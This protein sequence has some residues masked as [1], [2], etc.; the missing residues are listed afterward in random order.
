MMRSL[1]A[2]MSGLQAHQTMVDVTSNNIANANTHGYKQSRVSFADQLSQNIFGGSRPTENLGG[3]NGVQVGLGVRVNSI[4]QIMSQGSL[5]QTGNTLDLAVSGDGFFVVSDGA[6]N[7][8]T[9]NGAFG[10]D[11]DGFITLQGSAYRVMGRM[12]SEDGTIT[13]T[14]ST[15]ALK[16]PLQMKIAAKATSSID[17]ACNLDADA[18]NSIATLGSAGT[19]GLSQVSG[20]AVDG[21]GGTH[22]LSITG[23]NATRDSLTSTQTTLTT[24]TILSSLGVSGASFTITVDGGTAQTI[25]GLSSGSSIGDLINAINTQVPGAVAQLV[26]SGSPATTSLVV[27]RKTYGDH[28]THNL[29]FADVAGGTNNIVGVLFGTNTVTSGGTNSTLS[30]LDTF[31]ATG[32]TTPS[33]TDRALTLSRN[34][35]GL[36]IGIDGLGNGGVTMTAANGLASGTASITTTDTSHSTSMVVYDSLGVGHNLNVTFS[37]SGNANEWRWAATLPS[38]SSATLAGNTGTIKF[39]LDGSLNSFNYDGGASG[40]SLQAS[41]GTEALN[42]NLNAGLI[43]SLKGITQTS[44]AFSTAAVSQNGYA[45]GKLDGISV[46][47]SGKIIGS[48]TNGLNRTLAEVDLATFSNAQGLTKTGGNLFEVSANSGDPKIGAATT[49]NSQIYSGYLELSNVDLTKEFTNLIIGQRGFSANS[50]AVQSAD[51]MLME[52]LQIKR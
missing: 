9:R 41:N 34:S 5:E 16:L 50:R 20:T 30:A 24:D 45:S 11:G 8:Y 3:I 26:T 10:M 4:D 2:A 17:F 29:E 7:Y 42:I 15:G 49:N 48:F 47:N 38:E 32:S 12:A 28:A 13:G 36:V 37:K 46:D 14:E 6:K 1:F 21:A 35:D 25:T 44:A 23:A 40:V 19:T 43:G 18:T 31:T 39:N 33:Y 27:E 22:A 52:V 51:Q